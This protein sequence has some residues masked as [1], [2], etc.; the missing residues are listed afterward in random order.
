MARDEPEMNASS[1]A[2]E[3]VETTRLLA[4]G[5]E[6]YA[7]QVAREAGA[8]VGWDGLADFEELPRWRR[9]S[10]FWLIAPYLLFTLAHGSIIVPKLNLILDLVCQGYFAD[11]AILHPGEP[12]TPVVFG[13]D[14]PQCR[15]PEIQKRVATFML[16]V[17]LCTGLLSALAAPKLGHLSDRFGRRRL[18]ALVSCGGLLGEMITILA[19]KFP[20]TVDYRWLLLGALF[21]GVFGSFTAGNILTQSYASDCTPPSKRAVAMG[22]IHACMFT[23]LALGVYF[24]G[25]F[26][27]LTGSLVSVF[28]VC[29]AA[30]FIFIIIVAFV[31]PESLSKRRQMAAQ[32]KHLK[33]QIKLD[34][35]P[36]S[37]IS[38]VKDKNPFAALSILWPRERGTSTSL[39]INLVALA[40]CD[41][42]TLGSSMAASQV[43][44]LYAQYA[45][46]WQTP[47]SSRFI[48]SV[49]LVRVIVLMGVF[50]IIHHLFRT[51]PAAKMRRET[52]VTPQDK[53]GG[54]DDID[55]WILRSAI[56][57]DTLGYAGYALARTPAP[58]V[59]SAMVSALGGL[60]SATSQS[61][62]TKHV[63]QDRVGRVFGAMG[64][65]HALARVIGPV[66]FNGIY[67][68]T[69]ST[70][71]QAIFVSLTCLFGFALLC[72]FLVKP[73]ARASLYVASMLV[74]S[75]LG[76]RE[77]LS[78]N[79]VSRAVMAFATKG[80]GCGIRF[81]PFEVTNQVF[82]TTPHSFALVNLKPLV[83]G[84]V[85]V[86]PLRPH[87]R[88]TDLSPAET[89]DLF[90]T[91]QRTQR[92]LARRYF[93]DT[94]SR[95]GPEPGH[96][97]SGS[98]T[99]AVQDG[100]ESGQT[101]PHVHVHVI[102]RKA[103]DVGENPDAIYT[104]MAG[105]EG[106]VG[107]ALW[108][109]DHECKCPQEACCRPVAGGAMAPIED[110]DRVAR[111]AE[112]MQ[113]EAELYREVLRDMGS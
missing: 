30:H 35:R 19:A 34:G 109:R 56:F 36:A 38:S 96:L 50:P 48:A 58:F 3:D 5:S 102:P 45:F 76:V 57:S 94:G 2:T 72:T 8:G 69:V 12:W 104:K 90:S 11:Q 86:C 100:P 65:M 23:G 21:D 51:R 32:E 107:G 70:Y 49:S 75:G 37:W 68:A 101:V 13:I 83:P 43:V 28:Y 22:Y 17:N 25:E 84:H 54:A 103:K 87:R 81:G 9:P 99:V 105:E 98:F 60:G 39:R 31:I 67:A 113:R 92:M 10:I 61:I 55:L 44:V 77:S 52:G 46:Q 108:D 71:P 111:T 82:L 97:T 16:A 110:A 26:V 27:R 66:I 73:H 91:V 112:D 33:V 15:N 24:S 18:L 1:S 64:M 14:D 106:N 59:A 79:R 88:L 80:D 42:I 62:V 53:N 29:L 41:M 6:E 4:S 89:A 74:R 7:D 47:E 95:P 40:T 20:Q 63:P 85:L 78:C 93:P